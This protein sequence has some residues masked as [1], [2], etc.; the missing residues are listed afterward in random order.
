[1]KSLWIFNLPKNSS[2]TMALKS[3]QPL[4]IIFLGVKGGRRVRLTSLPSVSRLYRKCGSLDVSQ[5]YGP[6]RPVTG[7]ALRLVS[8]SL[9]K[10]YFPN[11]YLFYF[12]FAFPECFVFVM[13]FRVCLWQAT[14]IN[15]LVRL[16]II[17]VIGH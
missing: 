3:N 10:C 12:S 1:M 4:P 11:N 8:T 2:R 9:V 15:G 6:A 7:K 16:V 14:V 5:F 13:Y 17:P